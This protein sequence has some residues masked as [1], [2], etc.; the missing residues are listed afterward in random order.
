MCDLKR[1]KTPRSQIVVIMEI[2]EQQTTENELRKLR[3][4]EKETT[5]WQRTGLFVSDGSGSPQ[6]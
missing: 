1:P 4:H 5:I 3:D 6:Q 2:S